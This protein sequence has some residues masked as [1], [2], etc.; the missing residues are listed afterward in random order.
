MLFI[1]CRDWGKFKSL[2][3]GANFVVYEFEV[4]RSLRTFAV[5]DSYSIIY[6]EPISDVEAGE[7]PGGTGSNIRIAKEGDHII[8]AKPIDKKLECGLSYR[9]VP[10]LKKSKEE[11][12]VVAEVD[13]D[14]KVV[15]SFLKKELGLDEDKIFRGSVSQAL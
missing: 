11:W 9:V 8:S 3:R 4:G 13:L 14:E 6:E 2:G 12:I 7:P 10:R 15:T 1:R 5:W